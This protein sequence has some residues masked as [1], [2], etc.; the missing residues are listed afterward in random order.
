MLMAITSTMNDLPAID[1]H[2]IDASSETFTYDNSKVITN[3]TQ[4]QWITI[5]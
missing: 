4:E 1:S 2:I 5:S 3:S